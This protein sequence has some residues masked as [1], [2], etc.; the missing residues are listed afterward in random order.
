MKRLPFLSLLFCL[1]LIVSQT[2]CKE[3]EIPD[4]P[5][6]ESD[7]YLIFGTIYGECIGEEC[8]TLYKIQNSQIFEDNTEFVA[9]GEIPFSETPLPQSKFNIA[10]E[11]LVVFPSKLLTSEERTYGCPDCHDQ[12]TVYIEL[13]EEDIKTIWRIDTDDIDGSPAVTEFKNK[14]LEIIEE[15]QD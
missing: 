10:Q 4:I 13:E 7:D 3:D 14:V 12:G 5:I 15:L 1:F 11:L 8:V 9:L 6:E 2:A